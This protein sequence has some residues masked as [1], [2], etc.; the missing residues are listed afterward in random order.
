MT[1]ATTKQPYLKLPSVRTGFVVTGFR[2]AATDEITIKGKK[3]GV[4]PVRHGA[5]PFCYT[6]PEQEYQLC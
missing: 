1:A 4:L 5:R 6:L 3:G 2:Q